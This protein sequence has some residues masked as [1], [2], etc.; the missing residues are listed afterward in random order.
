[1]QY[2]YVQNLNRP[3]APAIWPSAP[4]ARCGLRA[5][6]GDEYL[7]M[8]PVTEVVRQEPIEGTRWVN[9]IAPFNRDL[10][11]YAASSGMLDTSWAKS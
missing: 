1:M 8:L 4:G 11:Y 2:W 3:V 7:D 9:G 10:G 6:G 5:R